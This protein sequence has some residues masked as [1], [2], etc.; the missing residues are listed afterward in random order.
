MLLDIKLHTAKKC[1]TY[2]SA[3]QR[4]LSSGTSTPSL[5][6]LDGQSGK[7]EEFQENQMNDHN[8][9]VCTEDSKTHPAF[10]FFWPTLEKW[11]STF[12]FFVTTALLDQNMRTVYFQEVWSGTRATAAFWDPN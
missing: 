3:K 10:F 5:G 9:T 2:I 8:K 6:T 4:A 1:N 7:R 11:L 12:F